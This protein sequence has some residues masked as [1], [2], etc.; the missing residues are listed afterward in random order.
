MKLYTKTGDDGTTSLFGGQRVDKTD[1]RVATCG[2]V[3]ELNAVV[4]VSVAMCDDAE[5]ADRLRMVQAD[6]F[7]LGGA[8]ASPDAAN[9]PSAITPDDIRRL[10]GWIDEATAETQPLRNFVLPG[11]S[12]TAA[13]LHLARTVCRRAERAVVALSRTETVHVDSLVYL[14]RLSD[15]LFAWARWSNARIGVSDVV[16]KRRDDVGDGTKG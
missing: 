9:T 7:S 15:L 16:W 4:G 1:P 8:L 12:V 3:D 2:D 13:H 6:L 5:L 11:G 14:N 10:E